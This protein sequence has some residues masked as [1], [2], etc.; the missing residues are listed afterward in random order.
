MPTTLLRC[1]L[2]H[3]IGASVVWETIIA[4]ARCYVVAVALV[5]ALP[6]ASL[7]GGVTAFIPAVAA[8]AR[9]ILPSVIEGAPAESRGHPMVAKVGVV[10]AV[11]LVGCAAVVFAVMARD[12]DSSETAGADVVVVDP[13][14]Q[15]QPSDPLA[16]QW[17]AAPAFAPQ[18]VDI[19]QP[20]AAPLPA[21][22]SGPESAQ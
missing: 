9:R 16:E 21:D 4:R 7:R 1:S 14:G 10:I 12:S 5:V 6:F 2:L 18:F 13:D 3:V 8:S 17:S 20:V 15:S 22:E 19:N 11:A